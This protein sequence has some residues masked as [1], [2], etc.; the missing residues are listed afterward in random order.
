MKELPLNLTTVVVLLVFIFTVF[1][2]VDS[3]ASKK[4]FVID[5]ARSEGFVAFIVNEKSVDTEGGDV[6]NECDCNGTKELIHGD[7][8]KTPCPCSES[9]QGCQC[10][11]AKPITEKEVI[12][13]PQAGDVKKKQQTP[14]LV[15]SQVANQEQSGDSG[16]DPEDQSFSED[17]PKTKQVLFFTASWCGPCQQWKRTELARFKTNPKWKISEKSD[18]MIRIV[19]I[20]K[21]SNKQLMFKKQT[22]VVPEFVLLVDGKYDSHKTGYQ[23]AETIGHMY[24]QSKTR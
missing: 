22:R 4:E 14:P 13:I 5:K 10:R 1:V 24:N 2:D 9:P 6:Q 15:V 8:H 18:A 12:K 23:S 17:K 7:G 11:P 19:D 16:T 20:D 21:P 3:P